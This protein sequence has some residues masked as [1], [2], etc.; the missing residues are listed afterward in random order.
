VTDRPTI[1]SVRG[2]RHPNPRYF[3]FKGGTW[4]ELQKLLDEGA[5][6]REEAKKA[7]L[8]WQEAGARR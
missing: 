7:H 5:K 8:E 2:T 4:R 6:L 3:G 1:T